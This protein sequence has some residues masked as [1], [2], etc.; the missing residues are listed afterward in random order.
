MAIARSKTLALTLTVLAVIAATAVLFNWLLRP[1]KPMAG[2]EQPMSKEEPER[3]F[4]GSSDLLKDTAVLPTLDTSIP[5]KKSAIWCVSLQLAWNRLKNDLAKEPIK[6]AKGQDLTDRLNQAEQSEDDIASGDYFAI[7]GRVKDGIVEKIEAGLAANFPQQAMP[8]I[9]AYPKGV[10]AFGYMKADVRYTYQFFNSPEWL[11]F[12]GSD[13]RTVPVRSF[14]LPEF[15]KKD[16]I[17]GGCRQQVRVLFREGGRFAVDLS[18]ESS[19]NQIVLAKMPRKSTLAATLVELNK[20]QAASQPVGLHSS[21]TLLVPNVNWHIEHDFVELEGKD[22]AIQN[23]ALAGEFLVK[24]FQFVDFKMDRLG[25]SVESGAYTA[26]QLL[27][28][29]EHEEDTNPDH[30]HFDRPF[31][32]VTKKRDAKHPFFAMWVDNAELLCQR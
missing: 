6:L 15:N 17:L 9:Q 10:I 32:I 13:G 31:L 3:V 11:S 16:P 30:Y 27:N 4:A 8:P 20:N 7:A 12:K 5:E 26:S 1:G 21:A 29:H 23:A 18:H 28:G 14:G 22:K 2:P 25:S 24:V 19:P